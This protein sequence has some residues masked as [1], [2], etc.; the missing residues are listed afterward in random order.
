VSD[1][2]SKTAHSKVLADYHDAL[3][4]TNGLI[5]RSPP[6]A[7][8]PS[9]V[10]ARAEVR[11]ARLRT[12][13]GVLGDPHLC[14]PVI[15]VAGT[16]GKGSTAVAAASILQAAGFRTGLHTSPYLQVATEKLQIDGALIDATTFHEVVGRVLAA[17]RRTSL[18]DITYGEAWF[19]LTA[20]ALAEAR[21]QVAVI[22]VG[23]GGRFDLTN[24]VCPAVS[25]I[26]SVGLDH[27]ETLGATI[28]EI[29]WHKAGIIKRPAPVVTAVADP[30]ALAVIEQVAADTG[31][32]IISIHEGRT[33][34]SSADGNGRYTWGERDRP[35]ERYPTPMPGRFQAT[36]AATALAAVRALPGIGASIT[37]EAVRNGLGMAR[38]PGRFEVVQGDPTVIL[39]GAH[40]PEKM[41]A[42][43]GD[44]RSWR[45]RHPE[46]RLIA[47]TGVL[48]SKDHAPMLA[49]IAGV[50]DEIVTT[51]PRVLAKPGADAVTLAASAAK[52]G[53]AGRITAIDDPHSALDLGLER[54]GSNDVVVV[55][56]SLYLVGNVRGRWYPDDEIVLQRT[57]WP[58]TR[59]IDIERGTG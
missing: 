48:E 16:S 41:T 54:S 1:L 38:I 44:L 13:L 50:A 36:N 11:L 45:S 12:L 6:P 10:R 28:P 30:Q 5:D 4:R 20:L 47:V 43:V 27:T 55:T 9:V 18:H 49:E 31:S 34:D 58:E 14:Y 26:T 8:S 53:F 32:R 19:A 40:N 23:A 22:E 7:T 35:M 24:V 17:A 42:L 2:I 3:D 37:P 52:P 15:H 59:P 25:V 33:F 57:S 29:A 39:D 21:V 56:G 46:A 51:T